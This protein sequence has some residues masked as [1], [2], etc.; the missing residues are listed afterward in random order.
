MISQNAISLSDGW[1]RPKG[2]S[3]VNKTRLQ[4]CTVQM[5]LTMANFRLLRLSDSA[6]FAWRPGSMGFSQKDFVRRWWDV[7]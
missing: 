7:D 4:S 1:E 2:D 3:S 5:R 6:G